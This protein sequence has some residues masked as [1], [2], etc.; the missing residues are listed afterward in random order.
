MSVLS[1]EGLSVRFGAKVLLDEAS[2]AVQREER[3]GVVGPNGAG[4]STLLKVLA[5]LH[6][7]DAGT[8]RQSPHTRVGYLAQEHG[9]ATE[10]PLRAYVLAGAPGRDSLARDLLDLEQ[11]L[12]STEDAELQMTL[13]ERMAELTERAADLESAY[14]PHEADR[15]LMGL[16]FDLSD[17]ERPVSDFSGGWRMRAALARLLFERNDVLILDE[18]TNHL[19]VPSIEWLS[20][21]LDGTKLA[22]I[23]TCHDRAF[24]NRHVK[25][26]ASLEVEGLKTFR[27]NFDAYLEQRELELEQMRA[28]WERW[29]RK[30]KETEAFIERFRAK[31]SKAR[32]AQS[33]E[34]MIE[35]LESELVAPPRPR[36]VLSIRFPPAPRCGQR[37]LEVRG[38]RFGY[39]P[40]PLFQDLSLEITRGQR[41]ALVGVN[42][43]GK[44]TILKL[45]AGELEPWSG[46]LELGTGVERRYF[47]QHHADTLRSGSTILESVWEAHP[48]LSQTEV[49][50]LCGAFLFQGEDVD[51]GV[52]VLSGGERARVA[53]ARILVRPGN[54]LLLDEP[55]NHLDTTSADQLTKALEGFDGT[56][57]FIS[58][59][60]D[61]VQRLATD[62]WDVRSGQV[63]P[64]P[65]SF[66]DYLYHLRESREELFEP[67]ASR[68]RRMPES[69]SRRIQARQEA[70]AQQAQLRRL[71]RAVDEKE[72]EVDRLET[73]KADLERRLAD[74]EV[75]Q[76]P[77][78]SRR[79]AHAYQRVLADLDASVEGWTELQSQLEQAQSG[80]NCP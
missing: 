27:G 56:L 75:H 65:G 28:R 32:Q 67:A 52:D 62:V 16:G 25:R 64:F 23:L 61:F 17:L 18:P 30:R 53:L 57:V 14:G 21:F 42:G 13:A 76:D 24:L 31:A 39:G 70:K 72:S 59:N 55:T 47:A 63:S 78:E 58:H 50:S 12:E 19:D 9:E 71:Q 77:E 10:V 40:T 51:K 49:R 41:V 35:K 68:D 48:E 60:L 80:A 45:L 33:K 7:P 8:V 11:R 26:I 66:E 15:I 20:S 1:A 29:E 43:S 37:V 6:A 74:P 46:D 38:L 2:L 5:G 36:P 34:K 73:E 79:L 22:L 44:T 69:K 54:L 3:L 4:K